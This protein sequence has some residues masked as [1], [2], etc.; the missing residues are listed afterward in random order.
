MKKQN[1]KVDKK[2]LLFYIFTLGVGCL[3]AKYRAR[4][5]ATTQNLEIKTS[6]KIDF[7]M[8]DLVDALGGKANIL[9]ID[10]T[11]SNLKVKVSDITQVD[12]NAIKQ[13]GPKGMLKNINQ[14]TILFGDNSPAIAKALSTFLNK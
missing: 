14:L 4:K 12:M 11:I 8:Q 2:V 9:S 5:L 10:S 6:E 3:Y 1:K 13:L 7:S